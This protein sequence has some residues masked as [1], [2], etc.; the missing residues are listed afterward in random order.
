MG[1][2]NGL[3]YYLVNE[4]EECAAEVND[5]HLSKTLIPNVY[6]LGEVTRIDTAGFKDN[7]NHVGVFSVNCMLNFI[8]EKG[9]RYSF[10]LVINRDRLFAD[11]HGILDT[12]YHF[13]SLFDHGSLDETTKRGLFLSVCLVVTKAD[14][15]TADGSVLTYLRGIIKTCSRGG[16]RYE[17][18]EICLELLS[19]IVDK[20]R[21]EYFRMAKQN[22]NAPP[23]EIL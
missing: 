4:K 20:Q 2:F 23:C 13:I 6:N 7:R 19:D 8:F 17:K 3:N 22:D 1:E 5:T 16:Y 21:I 15:P 14:G 12:L 18:K 10:M 9:Q 11:P